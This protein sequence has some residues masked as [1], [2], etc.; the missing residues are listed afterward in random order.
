MNSVAKTRHIKDALQ[1]EQTWEYTAITCLQFFAETTN[2]WFYLELVP[3]DVSGEETETEI[4]DLLEREKHVSP[5]H[6]AE[7]FHSFTMVWGLN[8][9]V[10][11]TRTIN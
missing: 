10:N 11:I 1:D 4:P 9:W 7:V 2:R 3:C 5:A 8:C 6:L